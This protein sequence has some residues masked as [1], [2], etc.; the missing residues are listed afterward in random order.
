MRILRLAAFAGLATTFAARV[1]LASW[2]AA[3]EDVARA[4]QA[5][6]FHRFSGLGLRVFGVKLTVEGTRSTEATLLVANHLSYVDVFVIASVQP[7]VFVTSVEVRDSFLLGTL[8]KLGGCLFVERRSR[9]GLPREIASLSRVLRQGLSLTL[10]P[11]G[12]T[13]NGE[14]LRPFKSSLL[15]CAR[16]PG[17]WVSPVCIVYERIDGVAFGPANRDQVAYHGDMTFFPHLW[18]L[19][20]AREITARLIFLD[21]L[22]PSPILSRHELALELHGKIEARYRGGDVPVRRGSSPAGP[23]SREPLS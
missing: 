8:C 17:V 7:T 19:L 4:E 18:G 16:V 21:P 1:A 20:S 2:R 6:L 5:R 22:T 10:F 14:R 3:N 13:S 15:E 12:T 9:A 23:A 11:E